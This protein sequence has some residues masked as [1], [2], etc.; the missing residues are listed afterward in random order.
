M[1]I[2][3][4]LQK[5]K[6]SLLNPDLWLDCL[7]V[8]LVSVGAILAFDQLFRFHAE[9]GEIL[10]FPILLIVLLAL[11][12]RKSWVLP[13]LLIGAGC[14][15]AAVAAASGELGNR[16]ESVFGFFRWWMDLFPIRSAYNTASNIQLAMHLIQLLIVCVVF[17]CVRILRSV[18]AMSLMSI[19]MFT[20]IIAGGFRRNMGAMAFM[21]AGLLPLIARNFA[22]AQNRAAAGRRPRVQRLTPSWSPRIAAV[23]LCG[24]VS[25]L[26]L[27]L[28]PENTAHWTSSGMRQMATQFQKIT[29]I[30][31]FDNLN[32]FQPAELDN[33]GLMP[34]LN[35]LGGPLAKQSRSTVLRL[36][37][38]E[39]MLMRGTAY[40]TYTGSSWETDWDTKKSGF[41][42]LDDE[43]NAV[44]KRRAFD[45]DLP[46]GRYDM[47]GPVAHRVDVKVELYQNSTNLFTVGRASLIRM[48]TN[49]VD[50]YF[51]RRGE[52]FAKTNIRAPF[53]Y[54]MTAQLIRRSSEEERRELARMASLVSGDFDEQYPSILKQYTQLPSDLPDRVRQAA[55]DATTGLSEPYRIAE[56]LEQ[57]LSGNFSYTLTPSKVPSG[58]D[59]VEY[60]LETGEGYCVY[61]ASAMAVMAR[62]LGIPSRMVCGYGVKPAGYHT[63]MASGTEAHAWV[64]CYFQGLGWIAFDPTAGSTFLLNANGGQSVATSMWTTGTGAATTNTGGTTSTNTGGTTTTGSTA[65]DSTT[66]TESGPTTTSAAGGTEDPGMSPGLLWT[67]LLSI[68]GI[69]LLIL[70]AALRILVCA[71]RYRI[72]EVRQK[73]PRSED[74]AEFYYADYL[75]QLRLLGYEPGP[76]ETMKQF[77]ERILG[78]EPGKTPHAVPKTAQDVFRV[79]MDWRY[80]EQAPAPEDVERLA[81]L[82][83]EL[84]QLVKTH[85]SPLLYLFRRVFRFGR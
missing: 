50:L 55:A 46:D 11:L 10:L 30:G 16:L 56:A 45:L 73:R 18:V 32:L 77:A 21:A 78:E 25:L 35:R 4:L 49:A 75:R 44:L 27:V 5:Q 41:F 61:F 34:N 74:Q 72:E 12:T 65:P 70:A 52:V 26:V 47:Y 19:L 2:S 76:N 80:G 6:N 69:L 9:L 29:K 43:G 48:N 20:V 81:V 83:E 1:N 71:K 64:E 51:N 42:A 57:Y 60:F 63:W 7:S 58:R 17:F 67:I 36:Y 8:W 82:H 13:V 3:S 79:I 28:L 68:G 37:A 39:P 31:P 24:A 15:Y 59:F 62:T 40:E 54:T 33:L 85:V 14:F 38:D 23:A 66:T 84:E 22:A 53:N